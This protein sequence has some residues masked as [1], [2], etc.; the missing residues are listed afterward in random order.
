MILRVELD[1]ALIIVW[2]WLKIAIQQFE[3]VMP[4]FLFINVFEPAM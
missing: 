4:L 2:V 3:I 1:A